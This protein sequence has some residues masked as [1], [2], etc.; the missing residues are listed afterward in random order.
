MA[1]RHGKNAQISVGGD[2]LS[3][4]CDNL[5]LG[6]DIDTA[7]VSAFGDTWKE[8]LAGLVGGTFSLSGSFD[9][10]VTTGP[11]FLLMAVISGGVPVEL[12]HK[13]GGTDT[14]QRTNTFDALITSYSESS[15]VADKVTFSADFII[16]SAVVPTTQ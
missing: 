13:P 1:F 14:G 4:F 7:E 3:A 15:P 9:P 16:D 10:T 2:D 12:I 6:I 5:D 8:H 11:A